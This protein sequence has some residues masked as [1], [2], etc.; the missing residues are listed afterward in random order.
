MSISLLSIF[1]I[2]RGGGKSA[3]VFPIKIQKKV[4]FFQIRVPLSISIEKKK[5]YLWNISGSD[6][7]IGL[8]ILLFTEKLSSGSYFMKPPNLFFSV[9][10]HLSIPVLRELCFGK[11][12]IAFKKRGEGG[13]FALF[14][15]PQD[16]LISMRAC[17]APPSLCCR[18]QQSP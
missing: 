12:R 18:K 3:S 9:S 1:C 16:L 14:R 5:T 2:Y 6:D 8:E 17:I 13:V 11:F 10:S 7:I 4:S 15:F